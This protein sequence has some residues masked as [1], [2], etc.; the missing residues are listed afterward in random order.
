[1]NHS[2]LKI[3]E[4]TLRDGSYTIDFQFTAEDTAII[5]AALEHAGF[6]LIEIGHGVGLNASNCGKGQAAATDEEYM[7]AVSCTLKRAEWGMF[8]IPGIGRHEDLE[9]AHKNGFPVMIKAAGGGGGKGMRIVHTDASFMNAFM[10]AQS[11]AISSFDNPCLYVEKFIEN[12][13]HVEFQIM[14]DTFGNIIHL[15]DRDCSIQ[16]RYQKLIEESPAP[17]L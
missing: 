10:A 11:E 2:K 17:C 12:P 13:R 1:M 5:A 8:F 7:Q 16:R 14:G 4:C 9:M 6:D 3:L 15:G